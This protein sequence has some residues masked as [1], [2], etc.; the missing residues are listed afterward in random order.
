MERRHH[1]RYG[2]Q[3]PVSFSW[4]DSRNTNQRCNGLL[5]N[6]SGVGVFITARDLPP[7]GTRIGLRTSLPTA[8]AG[9]PLVLRASAEVVR[10]EFSEG[11]AAKRTGFAATI[12]SFTLRHH[13]KKLGDRAAA[14]MV[15]KTRNM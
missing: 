4:K 6:I 7:T 5:L 12:N 10:L 15:A 11:D 1:E 13:G 14:D 9:A 8:V 2:L 3:A